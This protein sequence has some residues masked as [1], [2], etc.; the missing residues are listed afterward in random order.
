MTLNTELADVTLRPW[1]ATD[2]ESLV[3]HANN[4]AIWRNMTGLFPHP[5]TAEDAARWVDVATRPGRDVQRAICVG[6]VAC[7]GIGLMAGTDVRQATAAFGYWLGET[8]WGRGI[9][10]AAARRMVELAEQSG[11]FA[12]LQAT[13][14][15]WNP[16]SMRVLERAGFE[17][18]GVLRKSI[19]KDGELIDSV[20][21][22]RVFGA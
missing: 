21:F 18:E 16:A 14:Y 13:V 7:G 8:Y 20:L 1:A 10:T 6:G 3:H 11:D 9:A 22:A 4:R 15:Q 17:R 5:Y 19:T 12:R 2:A